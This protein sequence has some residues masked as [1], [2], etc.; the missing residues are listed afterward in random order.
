MKLYDVLETA[1]LWRHLKDEWLPGPQEGG[2]KGRM[3]RYSTG[4][5]GAM[6][7]FCMMYTITIFVM[8]DAWYYTFVKTHRLYTTPRV[9]PKVN[10]ELWVIMICPPRF[11]S[12][13]KR[14]LWCGM[15]VV[16]EAIHVWRQ[17]VCGK[18][19]YFSLS[20]TV[21]LKLI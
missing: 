5:F 6:I 3:N 12:Y 18:S 10:Y 13:H 21:N 9:S 20:F 7:L 15:S 16:E 17:E 19:P 8:L 4:I 11:I 14:T 2:M 1:K